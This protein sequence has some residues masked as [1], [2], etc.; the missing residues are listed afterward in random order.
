MA[1][2]RSTS[3]SEER[4]AAKADVVSKPIALSCS[5]LPAPGTSELLAERSRRLW[6]AVS[7][8]GGC[9][10][11]PLVCGSAEDEDEVD[12]DDDDDDDEEG[13]GGII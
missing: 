10:P 3:P 6:P 7:L 12:E 9:P 4:K 2:A 8:T 11:D 5:T 1:T 13:D